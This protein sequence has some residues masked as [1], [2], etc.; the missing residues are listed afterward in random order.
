MKITKQ[1]LAQ[2]IKE[3]LESILKETTQDPFKIWAQSE[4]MA[5]ATD[6]KRVGSDDPMNVRGSILV[7]TI[8]GLEFEDWFE[9]NYEALLA[10]HQ[11]G[12]IAA[13]TRAQTSDSRRAARN[14]VDPEA[15]FKIDSDAD[16]FEEKK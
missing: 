5:L 14:L 6:K 16:I 2:I 9:K 15:D 4:F 13:K 8:D 11:Q 3:E 10:K 7:P 12:K 1:Q